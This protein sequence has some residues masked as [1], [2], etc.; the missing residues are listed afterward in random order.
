MQMS[1]ESV[2]TCKNCI[3]NSYSMCRK[4]AQHAAARLTRPAFLDHVDPIFK[5]KQIFFVCVCYV[6]CI[7]EASNVKRA[8]GVP[9]SRHAAGDILY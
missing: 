1:R 2:D 5:K 7:S 4:E 9:S 8:L 3:Y 6:V